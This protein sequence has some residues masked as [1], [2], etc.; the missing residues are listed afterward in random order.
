METTITS[1]QSINVLGVQFDSKL[2][3]NDQVNKTINKA[4]K[5]FHAIKLIRKYFNKEELKQLHNKIDYSWLNESLNTF[6]V[7]CKKLLLQTI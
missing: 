3:W 4:K 2:T 7:K 5:A 1:K 6:K